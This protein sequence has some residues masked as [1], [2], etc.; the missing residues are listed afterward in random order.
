MNIF[1]TGTDTGV[2]KTYISCILLK[3]F[4]AQGFSTFGIKPIASGCS[5][6]Q[7]K[8]V[9]EDALALQQAA[10]VK[11]NYDRVNPIALEM[12]VS[13]NIAA[14]LSGKL[15]SKSDILNKIAPSLAVSA[16]IKIIEGIG[17]WLVPLSND[18]TM[19]DVVK[20]LD[21]PVILV[22]GIRLGCLNHALL[23]VRSIQQMQ[24]PLLGWIANCIEP[25]MLACEE[26]IETLKN[27]IPAPCLGVIPFGGCPESEIENNPT[28]LINHSEQ[29]K[30]LY[31]F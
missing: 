4:N 18:L 15:L 16:N 7:G 24:I 12:P 27:W 26:N 30:E 28:L 13:P 6:Q 23:T 3:E 17:G 10:S 22:V 21:I 11:Q 19:A 5:M 20:T 25:E 9:N 1:I 29:K 2:G 14:E 8:L 31:K